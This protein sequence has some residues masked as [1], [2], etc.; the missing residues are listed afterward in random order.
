MSTVLEM[1]ADIVA[2][3]ASTTSMT[4]EEIIAEIQEVYAALTALEKGEAV[5]TTEEVQEDNVPAITKR[6][7]FGKKQIFCMV[8]GKGFT[9]LK[10]HLS[11][12]HDLTPTEYRKQFGIPAG[13]TLASKDY[14]E[15]RRQ[16]AID[17]NLGA[18]LAKARAAKAKKK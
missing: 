12:A 10:R 6:K 16:M 17:K 3:H 14:S 13:T 8:C 15:S 18:G 11:A 4:K 2:A 1:A 9:T 7:A 5:E